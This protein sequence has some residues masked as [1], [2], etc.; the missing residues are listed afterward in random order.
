MHI[1]FLSRWFPY[2]PNNGSKLRIYNL[3]RGLAKHHQVTLL[4]FSDQTHT[5]EEVRELRSFCEAVE[6]I[7][8]KTFDPKSW[9]A[10]LGFL[11]TKPRSVIDTYSQSMEQAIERIVSRKQVD[12]IIASQI[13][14][15]IYGNAFHGL[16]ALFEE[17]EVGVIYE[18]FVKANSFKHRMRSGLTWTKHRRYLATLLRNFHVCTV[19]SRR[20]QQL[21]R[22]EV[23]LNT[24]IEVIPNCV[25]TADYAGFNQTPAPNSLI[26]TGSFSYYPNY[27]AMN[28]FLGEV[29]PLVQAAVPEVN[30]SIT[31][32]HGNRPLPPA[33]NVELTGFVDDVRPLI[34]SAWAS[35]VP[36]HTG[37]G[38]RLKI[39][40]A[41]ALRT[42][43]IA[44]SKGAEGLDV[45]ANEHLLIADTPAEFT[46]ATIRLMKDQELRQFLSNN[47]YQLVARQYDW[48]IIIPRFLELIERTVQVN[49]LSYSHH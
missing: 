19:V 20:E 42:P 24:P 40:E 43:V 37:G 13:D 11:S 2:P 49:T 5:P 1:L 36:L 16:P 35:I 22:E 26:F 14:M 10:Q 32:N 48:N 45:R 33:T 38:T 12:L 21:L 17:V 29:Y 30:L 9:R 39:L 15:A 8:L 23:H 31:G 6:V 7:P 47:A 3:L 27:E 46:Q 44:T 41:M 25:D 18:Q 4:T 28:W 34:K